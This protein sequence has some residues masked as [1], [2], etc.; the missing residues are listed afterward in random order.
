[1]TFPVIEKAKSEAILY[2]QQTGASLGVAIRSELMAAVTSINGILSTI[3]TNLATTNG[4]IDANV[5]LL[6]THTSQIA[7]LT[8]DLASLNARVTQLETNIALKVDLTYV[9]PILISLQDQITALTP[10][11]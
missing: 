1:M 10:E 3:Q 9:D 5:I 7:T 6:A 4:R 11:K 2:A 8:S